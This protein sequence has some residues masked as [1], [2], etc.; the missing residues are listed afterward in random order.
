MSFDIFAYKELKEFVYDC[1]DRYHQLESAVIMI[2][3]SS[4]IHRYR[5]KQS[6]ILSD[7]WKVFLLH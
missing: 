7:R 6:L 1:E 3:P 2:D 4:E 5:Y